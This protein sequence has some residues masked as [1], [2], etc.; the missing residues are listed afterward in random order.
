[1]A[2]ASL[3]QRARLVEADCRAALV[4][5][6]D[7]GRADFRGADLSFAQFNGVNLRLRTTRCSGR[8][9]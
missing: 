3:W 5:L 9:G 7:L 2:A 8:V 6:T 1:M 4:Q